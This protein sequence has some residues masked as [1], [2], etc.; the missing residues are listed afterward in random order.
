MVEVEVTRLQHTHDLQSDGRFAME[1]HRSGAHELYEQTL[2][3]DDIDT[4]L[5]AVEQCL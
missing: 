2:K 3:C 1:G 4:Y 5:S